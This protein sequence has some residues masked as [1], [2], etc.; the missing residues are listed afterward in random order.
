M[1]DKEKTIYTKK[2]LRYTFSIMIFFII[3]SLLLIYT[4]LLYLF[5]SFE[6]KITFSSVIKSIE[7]KKVSL[8]FITYI[9]KNL[10][11]NYKNL[12]INYSYIVLKDWKITKKYLS[13][14]FTKDDINYII[15]YNK[16]EIFNYNNYISQFVN[17]NDE[18]IYL[19][20][21][22][23]YTYDELL[24]NII[25][26][27][28]ISLIGAWIFFIFLWKYINKIFTPVEYNISSMN[29]FIHNAGHELQ[30]PL[31]VIVSDIDFYIESKKRED[32]ILI[33]I[34]DEAKKMWEL[35]KT[36]LRI[37]KEDYTINIEEFNVYSF[38]NEILGTFEE[39][40]KSKNLKIYIEI[41]KNININTN[42][43]HLFI[44]ITNIIW[45]AIKYNVVNWIIKIKFINNSFTIEDSWIWIEKENLDK[46]FDR[47]FKED[48][49]RNTE[50]FWIWLSLV[51]KLA[52]LN[53]WNIKIE[54]KKN[55]WSIFFISI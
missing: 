28:S 34:K 20:D 8:D 13:Y 36:L 47:F 49:S 46:I 10:D 55:I 42:K 22:V 40:I 27:F 26:F 15:N 45:N 54:S 19:I 37:S 25:V 24:I 7:E 30:T 51:K 38:I 17:V 1:N 14:N 4:A 35:I 6:Q 44:C 18:K 3:F 31:S 50:G 2:K 12:N 21:K 41:D 9:W 43:N 16:K 23:P 53:R 32:F 5:L 11:D 48:K 39:K 52:D 29:D 33:E